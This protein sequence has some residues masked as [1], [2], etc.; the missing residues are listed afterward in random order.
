MRRRFCT[1]GEGAEPDLAIPMTQRAG[2]EVIS[3]DRILRQQGAMK[4]CA[5][6]LPGDSA[7]RPILTIVP[8]PCHHVPERLAPGAQ[9][10]APPVVLK[11]DKC[12]AA[13]LRPTDGNIPDET[14]SDF[15][16]VHG[17]QVQQPKADKFVALSGPVE[18]AQELIP[19]ADPQHNRTLLGSRVERLAFR[20]AKVYR[21]QTLLSVLS[22]PNEVEVV[23]RGL[24][25][26]A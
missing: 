16:W 13:E 26:V 18:V 9:V 8:K 25:A 11:A 22:A 20:H 2:D 7:L 17:R 3:K 19:A 6:N 12:L 1:V 5:E 4:I 23:C 24:H 21:R 14:A 10:R 15:A